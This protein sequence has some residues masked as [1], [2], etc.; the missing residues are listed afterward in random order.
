MPTARDL[1]VV[2]YGATGFV[3]RL[4]A[5]YLAR[6]APDTARIGLAGRSQEKLERL[7][8]ELG[9]RAARWRCRSPRR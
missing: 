6:S 8:A 4:T 1:D 9:A 5:D 2:L 7:R 3:G